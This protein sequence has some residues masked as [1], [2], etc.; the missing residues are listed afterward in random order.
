[1]LPIMTLSPFFFVL[2]YICTNLSGPGAVRTREELQVHSSIP[3]SEWFNA[4][5]SLRQVGTAKAG[6]FCQFEESILK[7]FAPYFEDLKPCITKLFREMYINYPGTPSPISHEKMIEIFTETLNDLPHEN[8][9]IPDFIPLS[10]SSS[11]RVRKISLGIHDRGLGPLLKKKKSSRD[12]NWTVISD[13]NAASGS[14]GR[15]IGEG[16]ARRSRKSRS[17][18]SSQSVSRP[19]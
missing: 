7:P 19:P 6:A 8:N 5:S 10:V 14:A 18:R 13:N 3:L 4:S 16:S 1:M 15:S 11:S 2:I 17:G 12:A 9:P